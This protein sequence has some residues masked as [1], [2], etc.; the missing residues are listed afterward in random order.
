MGAE[1]PSRALMPGLPKPVDDIIK[2]LAPDFAAS[3]A[4]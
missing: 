3:A 4:A 1:R 2:V